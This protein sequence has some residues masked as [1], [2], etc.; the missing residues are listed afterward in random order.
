MRNFRVGAV[1]VAVFGFTFG[2]VAQEEDPVHDELRAVRDAMIAAVNDNDPDALMTY[3]HEN[4]TATW[5]NGEVSRGPGEV[6]AYYDRMMTGDDA[7]VESLSIEPAVERLADIYG[8]TAVA[9]GSSQDHYN[10]TTGMTFDVTTR[11]SATLVKEGGEWKVVN[12]HASTGIFD[13]ALLRM[14]QK[15]A[16]GLGAGGLVVGLVLGALAVVIFRKKQR[17]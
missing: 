17:A 3:L 15:S 4:V 14:A 9:H 1:L 13:N 2:A 6:R 7:V 16:Y 10:L 5:L 11:W 8:N 12:F